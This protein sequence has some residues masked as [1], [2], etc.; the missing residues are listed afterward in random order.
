MTTTKKDPEGVNTKKDQH[1]K[2]TGSGQHEKRTESGQH[3]KGTGSGQHEKRTGSGHHEKRSGSGHHEK[4]T[5]SDPWP[6][7][8]DSWPLTFDL[9]TKTGFLNYYIDKITLHAKFQFFPESRFRVTAFYVIQNSHWLTV[10]KVF[11][12]QPNS[13]FLLFFWKHD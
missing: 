2:R 6:L 10:C 8:F 4:R 11:G 7:T 12:T 1:E 9:N 5:G 13:P 3:E